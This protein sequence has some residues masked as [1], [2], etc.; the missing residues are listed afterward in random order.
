[1]SKDQKIDVEEIQKDSNQLR[2]DV[3]EFYRQLEGMSKALATLDEHARN[4]KDN[5]G[6][7]GLHSNEQLF[8]NLIKAAVFIMEAITETH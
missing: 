3:R 7:D 1:M 2:K 4:F 8:L 5:Y 6:L